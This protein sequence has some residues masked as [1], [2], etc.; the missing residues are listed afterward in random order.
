[1]QWWTKSEYRTESDTACS[2][3]QISDF[4]AGSI[5]LSLYPT[6]QDPFSLYAYDAVW[7]VALALNRTL[8]FTINM[9]CTDIDQCGTSVKFEDLVNCSIQR[10][11]E[12]KTEIETL[13]F[14]GI[15]VRQH[16]YIINVYTTVCA[17]KHVIL[18]FRE[19]YHLKMELELWIVLIY[20]STEEVCY[21]AANAA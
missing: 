12:I 2:Q 20:Y 14:P 5:S 21:L 8:P 1:M 7:T 19:K 16:N 9:Q 17:T 10:G 4:I 6:A 13:N 18:Y 15:S 11:E 3:E